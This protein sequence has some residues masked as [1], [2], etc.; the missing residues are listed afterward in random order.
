MENPIAI[1]WE[2]Q[3]RQLVCLKACGLSFPF[4]TNLELRPSGSIGEELRQC[5]ADIVGYGGAAGGGKSDTLLAIA[6]VAAVFY[7]KINVGYFRRKYP[8]LEGL[9][10]AINRS[11]EIIPSNIA[12]YNQQNHRWTF[13]NG[14]MVQFCHCANSGDELNYKSQQFDILLIDEGTEFLGEQLDFLITRNRGTVNYPTFR[15]FTCIGTNPGD[16]GHK[17]FMDRFITIGQPEMIHDFISETGEPESHFFVPSHLAD[18]QILEK[19]DPNYRRKLSRTEQSKKVYLEGNWDQFKGQAF[20]ELRREVHIVK[21]F[22]IPKHWKK[23][24][25][26]DHGHN[27]PFSFGIY[28]VD[29]DGVTYKIRSVTS[30]LKRVDEIARMMHSLIGN[31]ELDYIV[32]GHDCWTTK[33]GNPTIAEQ[34]A[35]LSDPIGLR[36]ANIDRIQGVNQVRKYLAWKDTV[37]NDD[38]SL[39]DGEPMFYFFA[40]CSSSYDCMASMIFDDTRPEDVKKRDADE[41]GKNGDDE[42]DETRYGLMSRP[43]PAIKLKTLPERNTGEWLL[44]RIKQQNFINN[45]VKKWR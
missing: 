27:H 41:K 33:D 14:S 12:E 18:N 11:K 43:S 44:Q 23:F 31:L 35:N 26:Y 2:P 3:E 29:D 5:I 6:I 34:F 40:N 1:N 9:G 39:S 19:R 16:V 37:E 13:V 30:R 4:D 36:K 7:P 10:G 45:S 21:P 32:A 8:N 24:G 38:G 42:Y 25:A 17:W 22:E 15:P 20:S 28:A